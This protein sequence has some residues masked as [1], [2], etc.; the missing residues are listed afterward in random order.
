MY[1]HL[2]K[3]L[4]AWYQRPDRK[5]LVLRGARQ[6]GKTFLVREFAATHDL[7]LIELNFEEQPRLA[8]IFQGIQPAKSLL[9][10]ERIYQREIR[11]EN[12]LLWMQPPSTYV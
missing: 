4:Q 3:Q 2:A 11:P 10:L 7:Q 9:E 6:V 5:P 12:C 1:R 8:Q